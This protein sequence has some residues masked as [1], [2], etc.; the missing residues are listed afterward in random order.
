MI[1]TARRAFLRGSAVRIQRHV[2]WAID[3]FNDACTRCDACIHACEEAILIAGDGGFPTVAFS[4]GGCTFCGACV[5]ACEPGALSRDVVPIWRLTAL[6]GDGC[7]SA[8]GVTCRAC[9]DACDVR[10]IRFQLQVGGRAVP[11]LDEST[12]NGC[13]SCIAA[14]PIQAIKPKEAA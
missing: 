1:N 2:P 7:V 12:C 8:R 9:G 14:C 11:H 4:R 13:G 6:I 10:A 3:A 5:E